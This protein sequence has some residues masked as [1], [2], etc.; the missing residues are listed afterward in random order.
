MDPEFLATSELVKLD[1]QTMASII[2]GVANNDNLS[3]CK[4]NMISA[5]EHPEVVTSY[6]KEEVSLGR[7]IKVGVHLGVY[8]PLLVGIHQPSLLHYSWISLDRA[9]ASPSRVWPS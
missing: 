4:Q 8:C 1:E 2:E 6:L 9:A 5:A 3:S 7:V